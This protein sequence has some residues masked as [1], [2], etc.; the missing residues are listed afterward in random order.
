MLKSGQ[1]DAAKIVFCI[2]IKSSFDL[3]QLKIYSN[4]IAFS[5]ENDKLSR[6]K[7]LEQFDLR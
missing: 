3:L 2:T 7:S 5:L 4:L 1:L 6:R